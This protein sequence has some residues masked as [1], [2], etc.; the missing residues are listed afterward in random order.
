MDLFTN[1]PRGVIKRG[2]KT[3]TLEEQAMPM[4]AFMT[5]DAIKSSRLLRH[6][7]GKILLGVIGSRIEMREKNGRSEPHVLGG[8]LIGIGDDRHIVTIAGSR[9]GKGRSA[10]IPTLL[11]YE[12]SVLAIDPKGELA[13][14]TARQRE[15]MLQRILALD[16]FAILQKNAAAKLRARFNPLTILK[17]GSLTL[18]EDAGLIADAL[19]VQ[20]AG[21]K[22]PHW[23][24]SARNFIEGVIVHVVTAPN[25]DGRRHLAMVRDLIAGNKEATGG[26]GLKRLR[27]E[28][29][30]NDAA[31]G[32]VQ[33]A[34]YDFFEKPEEERGSVLS[35]ARRHL[36]FL[37]YPAIRESVSGHDF[38][39]A[40][41]KR[42]KMT[43]YLCLP[44]MRM[45]TCN[46]W[47]RLFINLALTAFEQE[48]IKP[49]PPV[50]MVLDEFAT[51]GHVGTIENAAGQIAGF[52][53]KLWPIL[54]DLGQLKALYRERW[55]T[56]MG[57]A[58][59]VQVFGLNDSTTLEW[60]SKRLGT[61][62]LIVRNKSE[63]GDQDQTRTDRRGMSWSV[64]TQSVLTLEEVARFFGRDDP[65]Q[66]Q[67]V[68]WAGYDPMI[69]QR[70]KYDSH[71]EFAGCFDA[72]A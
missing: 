21:N 40:D 6:D 71:E 63:V 56:F 44:A 50:L 69:L 57:N 70:V 17:A 39:L 29:E 16:P 62:S 46:R 1:I 9:A 48:Q 13:T 3:L 45:T 67:L 23:D 38:D 2:G 51:L 33:D 34:A 28:M 47:F 41:L 49:D 31:G 58:G 14:I 36:R 32:L 7:G 4:A 12:G 53:V 52:G 19:V 18:I 10:I 61:T 65:L 68:L 54:Q 11:S 43:V 24:S 15:K 72:P 5:E 42:R 30:E 37:S 27:A 25:Y 55:E 26:K 66:R 20:E 59:V 64:Q 22:D 8:P 60:V 35:T